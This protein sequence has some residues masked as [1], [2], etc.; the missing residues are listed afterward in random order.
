ME[1]LGIISYTPCNDTKHATEEIA[2]L[3]SEAGLRN[4]DVQRFCSKGVESVSSKFLRNYIVQE[5]PN[6]TIVLAGNNINQ[7]EIL[8]EIIVKN[9]NSIPNIR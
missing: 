1:L 9:R 3:L 8:E 2:R 6:F 4:V 5:T 7:R